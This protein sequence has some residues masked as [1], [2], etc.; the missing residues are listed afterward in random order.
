MRTKGLPGFSILLALS[1]M[2]SAC[3][4]SNNITPEIPGL[5]QTSIAQT[6]VVLQTQLAVQP[7]AEVQSTATLSPTKPTDATE[8]TII[9]TAN[10]LLP[11]R[12]PPTRPV[13]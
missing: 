8:P 13:Q 7:T 1:I 4:L 12:H 5:D 6:V 3:N 2:M 9:P 11:P 10:L